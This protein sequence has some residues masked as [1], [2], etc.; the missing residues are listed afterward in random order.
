MHFT[1]PQ[2]CLLV[3]SAISPLSIAIGQHK[4]FMAIVERKTLLDARMYKAVTFFQLLSIH[5][6]QVQNFSFSQI[7]LFPFTAVLPSLNFLYPSFLS[8]LFFPRL[9]QFLS[10]Y[11]PLIFPSFLFSSIKMLYVCVTLRTFASLIGIK[12]SY[13]RV[14]VSMLFFIFFQSLRQ[15]NDVCRF[16][17]M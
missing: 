7:L 13:Q 17:D 15:L 4:I 6:V 3:Q 2:K 16:S 5:S 14:Q 12:F 8:F 11:F 1:V 9:L 10:F